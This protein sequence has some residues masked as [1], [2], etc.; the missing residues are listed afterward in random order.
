[1][2]GGCEWKGQGEEGQRK[3]WGRRIHLGL[4]FLELR[5]LSQ[6]SK[7]LQADA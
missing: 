3:A 2:H 4:S 7:L 6:L 5:G 1:M